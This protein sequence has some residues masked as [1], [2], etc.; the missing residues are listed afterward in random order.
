MKLDRISIRGFETVPSRELPFCSPA[1]AKDT[2]ETKETVT[3]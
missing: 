1:I 2:T 3:R